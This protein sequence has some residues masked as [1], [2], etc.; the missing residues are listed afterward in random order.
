M[1]MFLIYFIKTTATNTQIQATKYAAKFYS[2]D[3]TMFYACESF[4]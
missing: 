1:R 2:L 3:C 4:L